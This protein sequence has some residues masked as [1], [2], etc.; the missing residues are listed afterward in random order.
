MYLN[1]TINQANNTF[2][3]DMYL[4]S[5]EVFIKIFNRKMLYFKELDMLFSIDES[6]KVLNPVKFEQIFEQ[7]QGIK[8]MID[9]TIPIVINKQGDFLNFS[10]REL[11]F[12]NSSTLLQ[13]KANI[14]TARIPH[15]NKTALPNFNKFE[16]KTQIIEVPL[17][18]NEIVAY[19]N[20]EIQTLQGV[21]K[22]SLNLNKVED[23]DYTQLI[24][25]Y[26][27]YKKNI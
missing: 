22:Q 13:L 5:K 27:N 16:N 15:I 7:M 9:N 24:S 21:Q 26:L 12:E 4:S 1:F 23:K 20:I 2:A 17:L 19:S 10:S 25:T 6:N 3:Q 11:L 18:S 8:K 14:K